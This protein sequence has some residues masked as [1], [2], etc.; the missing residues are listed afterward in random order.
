MVNI[1]DDYIL[2]CK[3]K[4]NNWLLQIYARLFTSRRREHLRN[5]LLTMTDANLDAEFLM[6]MLGQVLR[7]ID[8]TVLTTSA[9][10]A[11]H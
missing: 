10:K 8:A 2:V 3:S 9:A 11:E 1:C 6:E 7:T 5:A 4:Q